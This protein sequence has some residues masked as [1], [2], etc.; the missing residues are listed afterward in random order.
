MQDCGTWVSNSRVTIITLSTVN[1]SMVYLLVRNK[2]K[3]FTKWKSAFDEHGNARKQ[4]GS[5]G[6]FFFRNINDPNE[7]IFLLEWDNLKN[8]RGFAESEDARNVLMEAG[9]T[10]KPD[11]YFLEEVSKPTC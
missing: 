2:V 11:I 9:L 8:A 7:T 1:E 3:D 5:K 10:D 4:N 6:G